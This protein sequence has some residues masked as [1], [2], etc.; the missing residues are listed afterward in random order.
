M[1]ERLRLML[2]VFSTRRGF[3]HG[4]I[5]RS[6]QCSFDLAWRTG[7]AIGPAVYELIHRNTVRHEPGA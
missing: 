2:S 5:F 4:K 3:A 1:R 7:S 6:W